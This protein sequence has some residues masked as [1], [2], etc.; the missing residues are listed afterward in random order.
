MAATTETLRAQYQE[1]WVELE[2]LV[3]AYQTQKIVF[4][5]PIGQQAEFHAAQS[6]A[7]RLVLGSNRSG[8]S[9]SGAVEAIAHALGYRPWLPEEHPDRIVRLSNSDPI[10]VPNVGR[11]IAQDYQQAIKQ[12]IVPKIVEWAPAGWYEFKRDNRGIPVEINWKNGSVTYLLSNDQKD[13]AF[14]G[15]NGH[16]VWADEPI[17][18]TKYTGLRRGLI[19]WS[20]HMWMTMTPISQPWIHD[21]IYTRA[22][23]PD[24]H[25][26][27]A[28]RLFKFSIWDN[29]VDNGGYLRR[30]DIEEY[31]SDLDEAELEARLHGNFI[32]LAGRVFK[33]WQPE[34]PYWVPCFKIPEAWPRLVVIDPHPRKPIAVLWV[35]IDPDDRLIVY[36]ELFDRRL[37]TVDDVSNK[38]KELEGWTWNEVQRKWL[39]G[40]NAESISSR[41]IDNSAQE[42]ERTSGDTIRKRFAAAG[43]HCA[44]AQ[45][46]NA[47]AGYDAIN[48]AL[49]LRTEW[50]LPGIVVFDNCK[51]VKYNFLTFV[52]DEWAT[53]KM[54]EN[55]EEKQEV[56]KKNDDMIDCIRYI[57]QGKLNNYQLLRG[58]MKKAE[59][60]DANDQYNGTGMIS[61]LRGPMTR[62]E[63]QEYG[64]R[65]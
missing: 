22:N 9:V 16:Y 19:D 28:V 24:K 54:R 57:Y 31:F 17:D 1:L 50:A 60:G 37:K 44:L 62:R 55:R 32:H 35:A 5:R 34:P 58:F 18:H 2:A 41:I 7:I 25:G 42:Q 20:G 49:K 52:W 29:C 12:T 6:A 40:H 3:A 30:A 64:R 38:I 27:A 33:T 10:P 61:G 36:R 53:S 39:R 14:E 46:Q 56:K 21:V 65:H 23:E 48:E 51:Q 47:D 59:A 11:I 45:K 43:I 8:K 13:M 4:Y 63:R 26:Y 15:T